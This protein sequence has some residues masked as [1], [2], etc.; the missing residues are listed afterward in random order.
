MNKIRWKT[1]LSARVK[2]HKSMNCDSKTDISK[3][4]MKI[5]ALIHKSKYLEK[6]NKA[7]Q[8]KDIVNTISLSTSLANFTTIALNNLNESLPKMFKNESCKVNVVYITD[9]KQT[10][11]ETIENRT[12]PEIK[13]S[14]ISFLDQ[15]SNKSI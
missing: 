15:F 12:I 13:Q 7:C 9:A 14:I 4:F 2:D 3:E 6:V 5:C 10:E 1:L 11:S 8:H